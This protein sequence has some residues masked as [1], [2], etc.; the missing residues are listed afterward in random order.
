MEELPVTIQ[1][2][3]TLIIGNG[4]IGQAVAVRLSGLGAQVT[5]SAR[6]PADFARIQTAGYRWLDTRRLSGQLA[7]FDFIINTVPAP[8]LG[9]ADLAEVSPDCLLIDLA[10]KPGGIDFDAASTLGRRAIW[11]LSLP[12]K[13]A[14]ISAARALRDTIYTI[15]QEEGIL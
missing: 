5:V 2:L 6:K 13:V 15:L 9:A 4:R 3:R 11:A 12:G 1:G 10:S 7:A 8:V 14:P